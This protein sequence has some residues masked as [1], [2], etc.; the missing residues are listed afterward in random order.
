MAGFAVN[1]Q[2]FLSN[3]KAT[4][5]YKVGYEEDYFIRSLGTEMSDLGK[6]NFYIFSILL[7]K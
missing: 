6:V 5:P 7:L 1:L 2:Y 3:P 4:M